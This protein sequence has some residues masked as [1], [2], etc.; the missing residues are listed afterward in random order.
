MDP[1]LSSYKDKQLQSIHLKGEKR[2]EAS[3][4]LPSANLQQTELNLPV[5]MTT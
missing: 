1:S 2:K 5:S 4:N 3:S